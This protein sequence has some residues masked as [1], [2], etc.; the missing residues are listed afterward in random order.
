MG[1]AAPANAAEQHPVTDTTK[2][3]QL[4]TPEINPTN[5]LLGGLGLTLKIEPTSDIYYLIGASYNAFIPSDEEL[6]YGS[7][8]WGFSGNAGVMFALSKK[9][10]WYLGLQGFYRSWKINHVLEGYS[11]NNLEIYDSYVGGPSALF[12]SSGDYESLNAYFATLKI[13]NLDVILSKQVFYKNFVVNYFFGLGARVKYINLISQGWYTSPTPNH[14]FTPV[15]PTTT[16]ET[17]YYPDVKLGF[18]VGYC[19]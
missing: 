12:I 19:F 14:E 17:K 18:T 16:N 13:A 8:G 10:D 2:K 11:N 6:I 1:Q 4:I 3:G 15:A 9:H 5:F 7:S